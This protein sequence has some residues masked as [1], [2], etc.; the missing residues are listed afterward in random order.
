M[1]HAEMIAAIVSMVHYRMR[2]YFKG[3]SPAG[4]SVGQVLIN[5]LTVHVEY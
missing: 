5:A 4:L 1:Q 3:M 2:C